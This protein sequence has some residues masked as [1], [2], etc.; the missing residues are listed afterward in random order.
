MKVIITGI[1]DSVR[2]ASEALVELVKL[3]HD[4]RGLSL[5]LP[6]TE[7]GD[8]DRS[9]SE[10]KGK[11]VVQRSEPTTKSGAG[12]GALVGA[13]GMAL[14]A[15]LLLPGLLA[16]G[17]LAALLIGAG[18]GAVSG[19]L[20]GALIGVGVSRDLAEVYHRRLEGGAA[21]VG[22]DTKLEDDPKVRDIL[23]RHGGRSLSE[24]V[25]H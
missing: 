13:S 16:V 14:S 9:I 23:T 10:D 6:D 1:F 22:V 3:G 21:M 20:L 18:S 5:V 17:P 12:L 19:G 25:F 24:V 11:S 15:T 2:E 4:P 8:V 7:E